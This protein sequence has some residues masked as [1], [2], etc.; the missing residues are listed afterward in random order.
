MMP[1]AAP[2]FQRGLLTVRAAQLLDD[3]GEPERAH[4]VLPQR[5]DGRLHLLQR[6]GPERALQL[7]DVPLL[8]PQLADALAPDRVPEVVE[9]VEPFARGEGRPLARVEPHAVAD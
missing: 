1:R 4:R 8:R 2:D 3:E 5:R 6:G 7:L 9:V